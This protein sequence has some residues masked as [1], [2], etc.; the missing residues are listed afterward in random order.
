MILSNFRMVEGPPLHYCNTG[1]QQDS[2]RFFRPFETIGDENYPRMEQSEDL[3][4]PSSP[5]STQVWHFMSFNYISKQLNVYL[6]EKKNNSFADNLLTALA[7]SGFPILP[8]T[9]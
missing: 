7:V 9:H 4:M 2:F 5:N 8:S 6:F 3:M 1:L